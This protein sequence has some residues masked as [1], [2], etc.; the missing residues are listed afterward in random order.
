MMHCPSL[1]SLEQ[2]LADA[3]PEGEV[4]GM[5]EHLASCAR[6]QALFDRLIE[7]PQWKRHASM[8]WPQQASS[9]GLHPQLA[10]EPALVG[11]LEKLRATP[12]P[13]AFGLADTAE[14]LDTSLGFLGVP[15][16]PGDLG[17]L[18]PY[19]V[20]AEL[21]RGGMGIVLRAYDPELRRTVAL[22]VL[23][24]DRADARARARFVREARAVASIAD[25]HVVPVY[26][27]DNPP[28]RP[29]YLV[30]QY[31]AGVTLR[32]R[33]KTE[34]R[35]AAREAARICLQAAK[36]LAAAHGAGLVHRDIKPGNIILESATAR[37]K[38]MDFGL[39]RI[40]TLP[41]GTTQEGTIPGTPEYM[42]PEQVREPER[43]DAR[44]DVYSLGVTLYEALT[45]E[46]PF[47]GVPQMILR[48]I[49]DDEPRPPRRLNDQ[50]P[51]DLETIC[52]QCL[53]K[54]PGKRYRHA[55]AL[56]EDLRR[57]LTGEPTNGPGAGRRSRRCWR[58]SL[59]LPP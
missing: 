31:V 39:V 10:M 22:K 29:P 51:R 17:T 50:I 41:G 55:E 33:I 52:L 47:R 15:L 56:A 28:D 9:E 43:I 19:R 8:C 23:P 48:Q 35:L 46:V 25:D 12:R 49:V 18:G 53:Q 27:V 32:Q 42:S 7:K 58:W 59:A 2:L 20:L 5:R 3:L 40:A 30:M 13:N 16:Y 37:A 4:S 11:L 34:G 26:A 36:G 6:C 57:F 38:I 21:G 45:G 44:T 1:K 54:E 24:P 14:E